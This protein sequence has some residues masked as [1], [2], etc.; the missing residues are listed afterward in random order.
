MNTPQNLREYANQLTVYK[1]VG[2]ST[3]RQ[4]LLQN[5]SLLRMCSC[6]NKKHSL[7]YTKLIHF[8]YFTE[9][10]FVFQGSVLA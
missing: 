8:E 1:H 7:L 5:L 6:G 2:A 3:Q 10:I 9:L 4:T